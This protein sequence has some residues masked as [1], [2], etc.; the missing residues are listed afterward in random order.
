MTNE[1]KTFLAAQ[2]KVN[3]PGFESLS[4]STQNRAWRAFFA[5]EDALKAT[6]QGVAR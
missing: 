3:S 2:A 1:L 4:K 5:A 6:A